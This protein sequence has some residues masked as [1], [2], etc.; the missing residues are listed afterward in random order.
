MV[1]LLLYYILTSHKLSKL[2][3]ETADLCGKVEE[4]DEKGRKDEQPE[5][6]AS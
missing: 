5:D 6:D 4:K 2:T 3:L 1:K